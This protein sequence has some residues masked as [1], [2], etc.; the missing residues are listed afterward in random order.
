M[1]FGGAPQGRSREH[2]RYEGEGEAKPP[3]LW[4][5]AVIDRLS[6][7]VGV[8]WRHPVPTSLV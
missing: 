7:I 6:Q 1:L 8:V 2:R 4:R 5:W 3:D